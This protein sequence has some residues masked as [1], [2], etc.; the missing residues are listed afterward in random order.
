MCKMPFFLIVL[1]HQLPGI[2]KIRDTGSLPGDLGGE[3][4]GG[5]GKGEGG[6]GEGD[7]PHG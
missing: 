1:F 2:W 6:K 7:D 5:G 4:G 3:G